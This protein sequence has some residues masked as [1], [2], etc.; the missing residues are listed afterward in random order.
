MRCTVFLYIYIYTILK[1]GCAWGVQYVG[2]PCL[3]LAHRNRTG[4]MPPTAPSMPASTAAAHH[5]ID[6]VLHYLSW[7]G[8]PVIP[9]LLLGVRYHISH[10][11]DFFDKS[12]VPQSFSNF[13]KVYYNFSNLSWNPNNCLVVSTHLKN[14]SQNRVHLP[15]FSG[16]KFQKMLE[17]PPHIDVSENSGFPP[18]NHPC[19]IRFSII[20]IYK[21]S[22]LGCFPYF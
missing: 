15:Q 2:I 3:S 16:W 13:R 18:P 17:K 12:T 8:S 22:I 4:D 19:L 5:S 14:M 11:Q 1:V 7:V 10:L 21:P 6:E 9:L 20:N